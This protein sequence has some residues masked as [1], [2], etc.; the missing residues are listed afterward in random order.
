MAYIAIYDSTEMDKQQ[1][2]RELEHTDHYW[3]FIDEPLNAQNVKPDAE[4]ISV[5]VSST[6]DQSIMQRFPR[7]RLICCRSTGYNNVDLQ[8]AAARNITVTNVPTYGEQTVA[9]YVFTLLLALSRKLTLALEAVDSADID[10]TK[11]TGFDL[12]GK[13]IGI[14][15]AGRIGQHVAMIARGFG[16]RVLA[17]D[18]Y[19]NHEQAKKIGFDYVEL[20]DLLHQSDVVSLHMPYVQTN[21][22]IIN[23]ESLAECK[24]GAILVNTARGELVDTKSVLNALESGQLGGAAFDVLEGEELLDIEEEKMLLSRGPVSQRA[25]EQSIELQVLSKMPNVIVTPHSAFNTVEAIQRINAATAQS[26]IKYWYG[27]SPFKVEPQANTAMGKLI[28][29][30]HAESEWNATGV[31]TGSRDVHLSEKGFREAAMFG[32]AIKDIELGFV[33]VS[34]QIR[35][36]ETM[37]GMIDAMQQYDVAYARSDALNE[38]DYGDYTGKN[39]WEV[40]KEIGEEAFEKLRR[41]WDY[42][43]PNGESLKQVYARTVPFYKEHILPTLKEGKNVLLVAHGNSIRSLV[44]Y[45]EK[46]S[47]EEISKVEMLYGTILMYDVDEDGQMLTKHV[48]QASTV[49]TPPL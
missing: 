37:S 25:L 17:Y 36:F 26:I 47:D 23:R 27:E 9:E 48:R 18:P 33:Y 2:T 46:L 32:E 44:K 21:R 41:A 34:Q 31:W 3:E 16:M 15:G 22:H 13:T 43:V 4:I 19:P 24:K 39:K 40:Q 8:A 29:V 28:V 12:H 1:L 6:V 45:I 14:L 38:R 42:P 35:A 49:T 20:T 30:R 10:Q 5:F 7:L 11:L